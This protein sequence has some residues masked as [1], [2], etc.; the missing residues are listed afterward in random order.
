MKKFALILISATVLSSC[1]NIAK[2]VVAP[3]RCKKCEVYDNQTGEVL[4]TF[5]G[6]GG[7]NVGLEDDAKIAAFGFMRGGNCNIDVRCETY[8][9]EE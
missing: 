4:Q 1:A 7:S 6:C 8:K 5:E 9:L 2:E 3:N